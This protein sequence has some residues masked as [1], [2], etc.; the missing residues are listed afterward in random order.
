MQ[1]CSSA[2]YSQSLINLATEG[3]RGLG[4][5]RQGVR[6]PL[7]D[8]TEEGALVLFSPPELSAHERLS[9]DKEKQP[10]HGKD[11]LSILLLSR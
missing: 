7:H 8:P 3:P 4:M 5:R 1:D 6:Q 9:V 2:Q 11:V 10:V